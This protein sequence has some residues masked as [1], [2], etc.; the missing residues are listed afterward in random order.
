MIIITV[1]ATTSNT[2]MIKTTRRR[3]RLCLGD[4]TMAM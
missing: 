2:E 1:S 3:V 4:R